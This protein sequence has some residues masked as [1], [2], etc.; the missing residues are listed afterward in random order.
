MTDATSAPVGDLCKPETL[1]PGKVPTV[2]TGYTSGSSAVVPS[3]APNNPPWSPHPPLTTPLGRPGKL[4]DFGS[5]A[6]Q[7]HFLVWRISNALL[8]VIIF[9][10]GN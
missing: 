8:E 10:V 4:A 9:S 6:D 2:A 1:E 7:M 5:G 3:L